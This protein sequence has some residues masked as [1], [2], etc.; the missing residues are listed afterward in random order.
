MRQICISREK[1]IQSINYLSRT[2]MPTNNMH[3]RLGRLK[4]VSEPTL[5]QIR[6]FA[7]AVATFAVQF[8]TSGAQ[9]QIPLWLSR[10]LPMRPNNDGNKTAGLDLGFG[11]IISR[12]KYNFA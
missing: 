12:D 8:S 7:A 10:F 6:A 9:A 11:K 1:I 3:M 4:R 5:E 2:H